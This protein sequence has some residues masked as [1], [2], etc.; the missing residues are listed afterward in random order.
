M[1]VIQLIVV[2]IFLSRR[3]K[4]SHLGCWTEETLPNHLRWTWEM[5]SNYLHQMAPRI[6]WKLSYYL[7]RNGSG[8]FSYISASKGCGRFFVWRYC[9]L[10]LYLFSFQTTFKQLSSTAVLPFN[11]PVE[12][13]DYDSRKRQLVLTSH[14]GKIKL[15]QVEKNGTKKNHLPNGDDINNVQEL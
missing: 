5:G 2:H 11:E 6:F 12:A 13:M 14:T 9:A 4:G 1:K 15:F 3:W 8:P 10:C 7:F